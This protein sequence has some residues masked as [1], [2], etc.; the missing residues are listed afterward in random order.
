MVDLTIAAATT[1]DDLTRVLDARQDTG[2]VTFAIS[3]SGPAMDRVFTI[4]GERMLE[5]VLRHR[6][7]GDGPAVIGTVGCVLL[8]LDDSIA[9]SYLY[10]TT[11]MQ[12]AE[13]YGDLPLPEEFR[14]ASGLPVQSTTDLIEYDILSSVAEQVAEAD[15]DSCGCEAGEADAPTP[16]LTGVTYV[17]ITP[18]LWA[19]M[20]TAVGLPVNAVLMASSQTAGLSMD[21]TGDPNIILAARVYF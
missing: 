1:F 3:G 4:G 19:A 2:T 8:V 15:E 6:T 17:E 21:L 13:R 16:D 7:P 11:P 12:F 20:C 9:A 5:N 18:E 10:L 14:A